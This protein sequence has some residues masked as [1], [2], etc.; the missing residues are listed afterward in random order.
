MIISS[1]AW[2]KELL[3][4]SKQTQKKLHPENDWCFKDY[5][6]LEID[7]MLSFYI[8]RKL[9]D[10]KQLT[11][12]IISTNVKVRKHK[13]SGI[14]VNLLNKHRIPELYDYTTP[15]NENIDLKFLINQFM[16]SYIFYPILS[17][18]DQKGL[19][20]TE[21]AKYNVTDEELE[22]LFEN[23]KRELESV[24][25]TSD[26]KKNKFIYEIEITE[27]I[28]LFESAGNCKINSSAYKYNDKRMDYDVSQEYKENTDLPF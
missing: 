25:F 5:Q 2:Q 4:I 12:R 26:D 27:L 8:I 13:N 19:K 23:S 7:L 3:K 14:S 15:K 10:A 22:V 28:K 24:L 9:I 11:N 20:F 17:Y 18:K 1:Q 16:H 21:I 6:S